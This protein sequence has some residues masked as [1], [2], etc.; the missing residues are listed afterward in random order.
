[1]RG[2][3]A[4]DLPFG[5]V[6]LARLVQDSVADAELANVVQ[7]RGTLEPASLLGAELQLL[8]DHVG[9]K[10]DTLAMAAGVWTLG[11]HHLSEGSRDVI[12]IILIYRHARLLRQLGKGRLM[13]IVGA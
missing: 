2:M 6:Q 12:E 11:I 4:H 7:Q 10:R 8:R 9:K 13:T 3:H 5:V 1:M